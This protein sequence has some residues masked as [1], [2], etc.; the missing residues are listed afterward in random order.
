MGAVVDGVGLR[1]V[2]SDRLD[3]GQADSQKIGTA[4]GS[5]WRRSVK[6]KDSNLTNAVSGAWFTA[7][8]LIDG[9]EGPAL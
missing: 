9:S 8:S 5:R 2:M 4:M 6:C 3:C 7:A 1:G